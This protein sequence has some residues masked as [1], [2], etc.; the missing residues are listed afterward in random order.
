MREEESQALRSFLIFGVGNDDDIY[1]CAHILTG[2]LIKRAT[3][4]KTISESLHSIASSNL[5][6][7][8][9]RKANEKPGVRG[10]IQAK[11]SQ[12]EPSRATLREKKRK[13]KSDFFKLQRQW[14]QFAQPLSSLVERDDAITALNET[15]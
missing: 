6:R 1:V 12:A 11:P 8:P 15:F 3:L 10:R 14:R 2:G 13:E 9:R 5:E 4:Q 7:V